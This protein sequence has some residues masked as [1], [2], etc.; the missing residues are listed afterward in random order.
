MNKT[1]II[2]TKSGKIQGIK[3]NGLEIFKGIPYGEP[4]IGDLRFSPPVAKNNWDDVLETTKYGFC[5]FQGYT[6]L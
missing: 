1:V 5:A 4:P 2:E 3:E 6:Q